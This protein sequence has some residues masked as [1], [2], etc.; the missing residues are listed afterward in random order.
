MPENDFFKVAGTPGNIEK[1]FIEKVVLNRPQAG[2]LFEAIKQ[3]QDL[4]SDGESFTEL[5]NHVSTNNETLNF[6]TAMALV[7]ALRA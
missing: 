4:L 5:H 2:I 1:Q 7:C 6:L 3:N